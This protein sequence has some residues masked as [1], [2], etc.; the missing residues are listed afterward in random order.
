ME[1]WMCPNTKCDNEEFIKEEGGECPKCGTPAVYI[2]LTAQGI[3]RKAKK[4]YKKM[5]KTNLWRC[6]NPKCTYRDE[7]EPNTSCPK[8][9][10]ISEEIPI[11]ELEFLWKQ[12]RLALMSRR[13]KLLFTED[14]S[15]EDIRAKIR[16]DMDNLAMHEAGTAWMRFGTLLTFDPTQQMLGA[17]FKALID[18]NKIIIRQNEL[19]LRELKRL[20]QALGGK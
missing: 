4:D 15:D 19:I 9:G 17:G 10:T 5:G 8:C 13:V 7:L 20:N 12:K 16:E 11:D 6:P 2:G 3:L 14:A 1:K 18:Q